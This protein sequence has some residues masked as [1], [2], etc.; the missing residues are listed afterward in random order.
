MVQ[1]EPGTCAPAAHSSPPF[2]STGLDRAEYKKIFCL[3]KL[4]RETKLSF[5]P[6]TIVSYS[7]TQRMNNF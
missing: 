1:R 3:S 4:D 5:D 6:K 2:D 7:S